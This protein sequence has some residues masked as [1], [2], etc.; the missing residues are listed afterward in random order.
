LSGAIINLEPLLQ[1]A[2]SNL[3]LV[4]RGTL[5][6]RYTENH[7]FGLASDGVYRALNRYRSGGELLPRRFTFACRM[8]GSLFSAILSLGSPRAAVS[9]HLVP[10]KPGLSS[11]VSDRNCPTLC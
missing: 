6:F 8:T 3:P 2:S 5:P 4:G 1:K 10:M 7:A 9:R 11:A